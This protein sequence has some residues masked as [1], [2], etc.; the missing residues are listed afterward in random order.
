MKRQTYEVDDTRYI[1]LTAETSEEGD[2]IRDLILVMPWVERVSNTAQRV[3][4]STAFFGSR[5]FR[6]GALGHE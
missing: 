5:D 1:R 6:N 4:P 2:I 3:E